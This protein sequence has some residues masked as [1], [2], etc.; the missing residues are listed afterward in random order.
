MAGRVPDLGTLVAGGDA[1]AGAEEIAA[2][3]WASRGISNS[4]LVATAAGDV[5]VNAGMS[6][7]G[8]TIR[9][10][11]AAVR[12]APLR[13]IVYTQSHPDHIGGTAALAGPDTAIIAQADYPFVRGYWNRLMEFYGR[14]T[15]VLWRSV[16][17]SRGALPKPPPD[18]VPDVLFEDRHELELGGRRFELLAT[19]GGETTDSLVVWLP[20]ERIVFT[21]NLFG[22]MFGH[23]PNLYTIRGDRIRSA[24]R[25]VESSERVRALDP[26]LLVTGHGDPIRGRDAIRAG[27]ARIRD[28]TR[29][30]HD[31]TVDGMNAG[32]DVH[33]LM[34]EIALPPELALGQGHGKTSWCVRA[35]WEEYAGWFHFQSTTELYPVPARAVHRDVVELAGADALVGRAREHARA[36]RAVEA[37]HLTD[38]VLSG[39]P[40]HAAALEVRAAALETLLERSGGE[41]FSEVQW[42]RG[43]LAETR[44]ALGTEDGTP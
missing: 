36:G 40:A 26:D 11:F 17:G 34:A 30:V 18:P 25:F 13:V 21:G 20:E 15:M 19:P 24:L 7:E 14:R 8:P 10:R 28:A 44:E 1:G 41:N 4:Y 39:E 42:L 32:K 38:M 16:L 5:V 2:G 6:F 35:I 37:L 31:R 23:L 43:R 29:W 27:L 33:Q 22:P 3:I 12:S 9:K